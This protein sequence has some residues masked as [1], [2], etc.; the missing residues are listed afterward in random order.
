VPRKER[1]HDRV[2]SGEWRWADPAGQQRAVREDELRAGLAAGLIPPNAPVWRD[3]WKEWKPAHS[4]PE[5]TT[6]ALSAANGVIPNIPPPPLGVIHVQAEVEAAS[7]EALGSVDSLPPASGGMGPGAKR[8]MAEPPPPPSYVPAPTRV[9]S[10]PPP[11]TSNPGPPPSLGGSPTSSARSSV[12]TRLAS[13]SEAAVASPLAPAPHSPSHPPVRIL[14]NEN[15]PQARTSG[16]ATNP[17]PVEDVSLSDMA[18]RASFTD[19]RILDPRAGEARNTEPRSADARISEPRSDSRRS[20]G[21]A[22]TLLGL[23]A[24]DIR[25]SLSSS[26]SQEPAPRSEGDGAFPSPLAPLG[27][28]P[29]SGEGPGTLPSP[30][31]PA[32][33][34]ASMPSLSGEAAG[35]PQPRG[36]AFAFAALVAVG[37][38]GVLAGIIALVR[39]SPSE[40]PADTL[41]ASANSEIV[42][43][44]SAR[45]PAAPE[46]AVGSASAA[47][48]G[49]AHRP[50]AGDIPAPAPAAPAEAP[51]ACAAG[52]APHLVAA[53]VATSTVEAVPFP[54]GKGGTV[55]LGFASG[56]KEAQVVEVDPASGAVTRGARLRAQTAVR[57]V[58]PVFTGGKV[59]P[60]IDFEKKDDKVGGRRAVAGDASI[61]VGAVDGSLAVVARGKDDGTKLWSLEGSGDVDAARTIPVEFEG[62]KGYAIAF[63]RGSA[64]WLGVAAGDP[65]VPKGPLHKLA[66]LGTQVGAPTLAALGSA[67]LVAWADRAAAS[68]PWSVRLAHWS[69]GDGEPAVST[70]AVP[71]GGLGSN[72]MSPGLAAVGADRFL[73]AWT[74]GPVSGH[75]VRAQTL[76]RTGAPVGEALTVSPTGLNAGQPQPSVLADGRGVVA[77]VAAKGRNYDVMASPVTC[78][79]H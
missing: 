13:S 17:D 20:L 1:Y 4:V 39:K 25:A 19:P 10:L 51:V 7:L 59:T 56:P 30:P 9:S 29:S 52:P 34:R 74:E 43:A 61:D 69:V 41:P 32:P 42:P 2:P 36:R 33:R 54:H 67:L 46:S 5:L 78:A 48:T 76:S 38:L 40:L 8:V 66:S 79:V 35:L 23:S 27:P 16:E 65:L 53:H 37:A 58:V 15:P 75:Q 55:A 22:G 57:H 72:A 3:G 26:P 44:P 62:A 31:D 60:A 11:R 50:N 18:G 70:Y 21:G 73:L 6:S 24:P 63:R 45:L 14:N 64:V 28:P 12:L 68:D 49:E 77:F 47:A 71:P